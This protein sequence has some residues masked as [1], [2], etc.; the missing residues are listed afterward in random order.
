MIFDFN[1]PDE[2]GNISSEQVINNIDTI[3][4]EINFLNRKSYNLRDFPVYRTIKEFSLERFCL[5]FG[6]KQTAIFRLTKSTHADKL[7]RLVV[8]HCNGLSYNDDKTPQIIDDKLFISQQYFQEWLDSNND[9]RFV[10]ALTALFL[11]ELSIQSYYE[12]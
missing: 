2:N 4:R 11:N 8:I 9:E 12:N 5:L 1:E 10:I 3:K 7:P 6:L